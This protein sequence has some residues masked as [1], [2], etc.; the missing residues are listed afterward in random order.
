[1]STFEPQITKCYR[2]SLP[3]LEIHQQSLVFVREMFKNHSTV[4]LYAAGVVHKGTCSND[5]QKYENLALKYV[6]Y[7]SYSV[8]TGLSLN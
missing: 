7:S 5:M 2:M 3:G 1:M 4:R 6:S 8:D